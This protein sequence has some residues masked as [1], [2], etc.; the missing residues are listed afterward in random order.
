[1]ISRRLLRI[2]VLKGVF[3]C[4]NANECSPEAAKK[5][6]TSSIFKTYELYHYLMLLAEE[7][8]DHAQQQLEL[9]KQKRLATAEELNP[10]TKFIDNAFVKALE[11]NTALQKF[12]EK[13]RLSWRTAS[14]SGIVKKLYKSVVESDLYKS[15]MGSPTRSFADDRSFIIKFYEEQLENSEPLLSTLEEQ[16]ILWIDDVEFT[17]SQIIKTFKTFKPEQSP[18]APLLPLFKDQDDE[19]FGARLLN[20]A[21]TCSD[22]YRELVDKHTRNWD[23]ERIA[24]MDIVIMVTA[25]AELVEFPEIPV[26]VSLN[27]YIEIAKYYSTPNS[28]TFINGVLDKVVD[29]LQRQQLLQKSGRG[30]A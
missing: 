25:I 1:M 18:D 14:T 27:E 30:V 11:A 29:D 5:A 20:R 23:V 22:E 15:Y 2:K 26:K 16:S 4:L 13:Q 9:G 28:S 12:C 17:L 6:L 8:R 19:Q 3:S 24:F 21:V 10:N 7:L